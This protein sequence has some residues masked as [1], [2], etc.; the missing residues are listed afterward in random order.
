MLY[1]VNSYIVRND[2]TKKFSLGNYILLS[3]LEMIYATNRKNLKLNLGLD[4]FD[5]K[6][7]WKPTK[8]AQLGFINE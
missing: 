2:Y 1:W 8:C 6:K 4:V 3:M 5:Y 7:V